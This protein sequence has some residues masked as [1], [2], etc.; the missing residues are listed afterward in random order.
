M[1]FDSETASFN[2][3]FVLD[4]SIEAPS[5]LYLNSEYWYPKGYILTFQDVENSEL[6]E[7]ILKNLDDDIVA[8]Q[9]KD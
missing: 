8:F 9:F 3:N 1:K 4:T 5:L 2:S 6:L 7:P